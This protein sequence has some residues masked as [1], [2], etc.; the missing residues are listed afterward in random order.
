M[1]GHVLRDTGFGCNAFLGGIAANYNTNFWSSKENNVVVEAD[2]YDRSFLKLSP[3]IAI[4]TAVDADHLDI[5][6]TAEEVENA[7]VQF[8][9]KIKV[10]GCLILKHGLHIREK[11]TNQD[12]CTY[13]VSDVQADIHIEN[14]QVINDSYHFDV[15]NKY[16]SIKDVVLN[17]GGLHN[18]ENALAA[19]GVA[20]YLKIE[21]E[22][23]KIS[24][25]NFK[26]VKR[27]FEY[28]VKNESHILI[29]DYAHHPDELKALIT[30]VR[31][32]YPNYKLT[33]IFQPHL[34]TRTR[35]FAD[36][37]A[38]SLD[39]A[40]ETI[41]LPIYPARELPIE[42]V[43]SEMILDR[44]KTTGKRLLSKNELLNFIKHNQP[45]LIIM[46]GAGD[47]DVMV[48]EIKNLIT[49]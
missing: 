47:I 34:Y 8:S 12:T 13:S 21:D 22:K 6:G 45:K 41:L 1:I 44:M 24:L 30:G 19:I 37:F 38:S 27:R 15:I 17:M 2:E 48:N 40:D 28:I 14:L 43:N 32:I 5:Y 3:N 46:A 35:D 9:Q 7:F 11:F 25:A 16:W 23:I 33:L 26:G 4:I 29:D 42:G 10:G 18:I 36:G 31:S 49:P 20:K 39:M